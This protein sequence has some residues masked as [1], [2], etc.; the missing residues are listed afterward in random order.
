V[1]GD[2]MVRSRYSSVLHLNE[3]NVFSN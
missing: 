3:N 1:C 2:K